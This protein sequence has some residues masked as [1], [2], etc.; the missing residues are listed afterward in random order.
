MAANI[1]DIADA[2][3]T[4]LNAQSFSQ[5][6]TA[7][8][9]YVYDISLP[10]HSSLTVSVWPAGYETSPVA[11]AA[12]EREYAI[13]VRV[14]KKVAVTS[15]TER[16]SSIDPMM[17][18]VEEIA[19]YIEPTETSDELGPA[20]ATWVATD[21]NEIDYEQL[22]ELNQFSLVLTFTFRKYE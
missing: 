12:V 9:D 7:V 11:R 10:D 17:L 20:G 22:N 8:R 21:N 19:N 14:A 3:V 16:K 13:H 15:A 2:V 4:G 5:S 1:I 6:F 18:L